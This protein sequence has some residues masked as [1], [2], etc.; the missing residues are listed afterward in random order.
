MVR[1]SHFPSAFC[2]SWFRLLTNYGLTVCFF[3]VA[4]V[5]DKIASNK[6]ESW[7]IDEVD[8]VCNIFP[9]FLGSEV[10][11]STRLLLFAISPQFIT[12]FSSF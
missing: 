6:T 7:I 8:K 12:Y 1:L 9:G 10:R 2:F 4:W 3:L 11:V 5:E